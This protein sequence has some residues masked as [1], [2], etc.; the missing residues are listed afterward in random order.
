MKYI[1]TLLLVFPAM[2]FAFESDSDAFFMGSTLT[3]LSK[4]QDQNDESAFFSGSSPDFSYGTRHPA[5]AKKA[6]FQ[7]QD[8]GF[9][10]G[11]ST[12]E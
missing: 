7:F 3:E 11:S 4:G 6:E 1:L 10:N 5:S 9:F 12:K 8:D 2:A